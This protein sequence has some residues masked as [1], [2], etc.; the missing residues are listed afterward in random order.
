MRWGGTTLEEFKSVK[1]RPNR[2]EMLLKEIDAGIKRWKVSIEQHSISVKCQFSNSGMRILSLPE[3]RSVNPVEA[4]TVF[5][6]RMFIK[7]LKSLRTL[8]SHGDD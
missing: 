4:E 5:R 6:N 1:N 2:K 7:D 8:I 3:M